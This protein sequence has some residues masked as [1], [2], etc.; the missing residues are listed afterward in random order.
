MKRLRS[1]SPSGPHSGLKKGHKPM[2]RH[3]VPLQGEFYSS[4]RLS[5]ESSYHACRVCGP[6]Q[7]VGGFASPLAQCTD[8]NNYVRMIHI[9]RF[10]PAQ[11]VNSPGGPPVGSSETLLT[12]KYKSPSQSVALRTLN[13]PTRQASTPVPGNHGRKPP[14]EMGGHIRRPNDRIILAKRQYFEAEN[15]RKL[16]SLFSA[17]L[18]TA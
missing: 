12:P 3:S 4:F 13:T 14:K 15:W 11:A 6:T 1:V 18:S 7:P 5:D 2:C 17:L 9:R 8:S 16:P 10:P